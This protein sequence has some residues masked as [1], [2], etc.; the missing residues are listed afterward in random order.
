V[1]DP[2][3]LFD[4]VCKFCNGSVN[5]IID[6]DPAARVR[7]AALQSEVGQSL[8]RKFGL[9]TTDF[10][11]LVLVEG[12][13]CSTRSTAAL[14]IAFYLTAPW[15]YLSALQLLPVFLRDPAYVLLARNR[16]RWF[17]QLDACRVPTPDIRARFLG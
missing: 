1:A 2:I 11:T 9:K 4:G 6:H 10:D 7:F 3:I 15:R 14:R 8:L 17:G 12:E 13:R 5:F 16:Y